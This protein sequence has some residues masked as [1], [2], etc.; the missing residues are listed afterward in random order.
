MKQL[1][2]RKLLD[3]SVI[4]CFNEGLTL[5]KTAAKLN[6]STITIYRRAKA[7]NLDWKTKR[8][9][10]NLIKLEDILE[11]KYPE[12]Q[13]F[14]LKLRLLTDGI[15]ENKCSMCGITKWNG[16]DINMQLDHIDG[17]PHNHRLNNL[18]MICPNC[19]SQ[20]DTYCGKNNKKI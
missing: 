14:K 9:A 20:T 13:T 7:L 17:N 4:N 15:F 18:R 2:N 19:H 3:L 10:P 12:Y 5:T 11:G 6:V 16:M 8:V 1:H